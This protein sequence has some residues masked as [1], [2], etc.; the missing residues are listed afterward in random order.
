ME[1]VFITHYSLIIYPI[2]GFNQ[3]TSLDSPPDISI[4]TN[5]PLKQLLKRRTNCKSHS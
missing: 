3:S 5:H 1:Y 4:I 2:P